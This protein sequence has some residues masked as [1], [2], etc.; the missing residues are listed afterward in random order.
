MFKT[1]D[2]H[3]RPTLFSPENTM[4]NTM[5]ERLNGHWSGVFYQKIFKT[6]DESTFSPLYSSENGRPNFP[7]NI[8]AGLEILK[9]LHGLTDEQLYENY[10]FNYTYQR[11]LGIENI[12]DYLFELR[13]LYYFRARLA[14]YEEEHEESLY[15]N[16]FQ[17]IRDDIISELG[18]KTGYQR[19]DSVMIAANIKKMNR[20]MLFHKVYT[21]LVKDIQSEGI[22]L[23][24]KYTKFLG[25]D[26]DA[27][28]FKLKKEEVPVKLQEI[29]QRLSQLVERFRGSPS[30]AEIQSY[31]DAVRLLG[32]QTRKDDNNLRLIPA[33]EIS[34]SSMQNPADGDATYRKKNGTEYR[35]YS[36][37]AAETC[38]PE[39]PV[40]IITD[41]VLTQNNVDDAAT[42]KERIPEMRKETGLSTAI[43]D[44][45]YVSDET[46]DAACES[47]V[48]LIASAIRGKKVSDS[49]LNTY[50][51]EYDDRGLIL[52]CPAGERPRSQKKNRDGELSANF[53]PATCNSC[54]LK[55]RCITT[56]SENSARVVIDKHRIWLDTRQELLKTEGY[57]RL[58]RL[59]PAVE[60]LM[61]KMKPKELNGRTRFRGKERVT[62]RMIL[63]AIGLNFRRYR[64]WLN[65]LMLSILNLRYLS[66]KK[67]FAA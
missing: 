8:L 3:L 37:H 34:S 36:L 12:E 19:I 25:E 64:A 49:A 2:N 21:N 5:K 57:K 11:A 63:K 22:F 46:R 67:V 13:T 58:C 66:E 7:V 52:K 31:Q 45:G 48:G 6:I 14:E 60:G 39:N 16:V 62:S 15:L 20:L 65:D 50:S 27:L 32:E 33:E 29:A 51:F 54:F 44:G 9:E 30:V 56:V 47:G 23:N 35:G 18:L 53:D 40:Q 55:K 24:E 17:N 61:E 59:R 28:S 41:V 4:K 26:E 1:N 43:V 42:F 10:L 38:D